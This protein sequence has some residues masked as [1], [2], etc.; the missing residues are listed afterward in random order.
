MTKSQM[1]VEKL[2]AEMKAGGMC[3]KNCYWISC[4]LGAGACMGTGAFIYAS[5]FSQYGTLGVGII[6]PGVVLYTALFRII[7]ECRYKH[8]TGRWIK[9]KGSRVMTPEGKLI[10]K[11]WIPVIVNLLT[12]GGY[13]C[14]MSF[15][16]KLAKASGLNQ[17][18]ISTLLS[19]AS[20]MNIIS[21]YF[22]FGETISCLHLIGVFL[23]LACITFISM[24]ATTGDAKADYDPD[25]AFGMS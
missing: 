4:S 24:A 16:W 9:P 20:L 12:N 25:K 1:E 7:L 13:L 19:L 15:G 23:M 11:S 2:K 14:V 21:F 10:W 6:G 8:K 18:V 5:N 22:K 3:G 17:G